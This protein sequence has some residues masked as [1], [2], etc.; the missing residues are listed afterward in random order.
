[1][2]II[3]KMLFES[4][5]LINYILIYDKLFTMICLQPRFFICVSFN[6][7]TLFLYMYLEITI[8]WIYFY[9]MLQFL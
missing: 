2:T 9:F 7:L 5:Y 3:T 4:T 1:M 6:I 8:F